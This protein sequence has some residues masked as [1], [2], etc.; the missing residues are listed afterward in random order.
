[1]HLGFTPG[2]VHVLIV[3]PFSFSY[4]INELINTEKDYVQDLGLVVNG[5]MKSIKEETLPEGMEGRDAI[6]FGNIRQIYEWHDET[7]L[8]EIEKCLDDPKRIGSIFIRY[9]RRLHMYVKYCENKPKSEFIVADYNDFFEEMR[10]KM[11]HRLRL[12]DLLIKPV[13]R[14]TKYQLL[15]KDVLKY[16]EKAGDD[17]KE[18]QRAVQVM[19]VV[20]KQ[21]N[22]MMNVGRLQGFE[23]SKCCG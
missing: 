19:Y 16:T 6:V 1:M 10:T 23:V 20:P 12:A 18:L 4:V 15:L 21:A 8:G 3:F 22:D 7:F 14:I 17:T 11:G 2:I 9:E 5:Y 13:Q